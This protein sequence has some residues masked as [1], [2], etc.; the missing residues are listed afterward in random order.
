[1]PAVVTVV[2]RAVPGSTD[3]ATVPRVAILTEAALSPPSLG[4]LVVAGAAAVFSVATAVVAGAAAIVSAAVGAGA[5]AVVV[6]AAAVVVGA[7][8]VVVGR[9]PV[10]VGAASVVVGAAVVVAGAAAVVAG[11]AAAVSTGGAVVSSAALVV[12]SGLIAACVPLFGVS[13]S[14]LSGGG[15]GLSICAAVSSAAV[16]VD[17]SED[18]DFCS[19]GNA[20]VCAVDVCG[21]MAT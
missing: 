1:L 16:L 11:A 7:T 14:R 21:S 8:A 15:A 17:L 20:A 13:G 3:S 9:A 18:S 6:G 12:G 2:F 5:A 4:A 10:V 19:D